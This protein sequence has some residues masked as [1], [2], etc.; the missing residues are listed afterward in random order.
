MRHVARSF[1]LAVLLL[2]LTAGAAWAQATGAIAGTIHDESGA[3]LPGVTITATHS[4]TGVT[5]TTVSNEP[6]SYSLPNLPL[7]PYSLE[8][9]RDGV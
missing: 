5:R 1:S 9:A 8:A 3:V 6:G 7:G 4:G 2:V